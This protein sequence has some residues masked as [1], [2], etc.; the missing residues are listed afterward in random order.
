MKT[1]NTY[2]TTAT[3]IRLTDPEIRSIL[4][5]PLRHIR[6]R[7]K[8]TPPDGWCPVVGV[9]TSTAVDPRT[10]E[11]MPGPERYGAG[12]EDFAVPSPYGQPGDRLWVQEPCAWRSKFIWPN[13]D[14]VKGRWEDWLV[15]Q[16]D[17]GDVA[18]AQGHWIPS[19]CMDRHQSRIT[20]TITS[21]KVE[22]LYDLYE[23]VWVIGFEAEVKP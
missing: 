6:R 12:D 7:V 3:P 4:A 23:W 10:G 22:P 2:H 21:V 11:A 15:Y 20:L 9:Y 18:A 14:E 17:M 13:S 5:A 19:D 16:A 1:G 8:P